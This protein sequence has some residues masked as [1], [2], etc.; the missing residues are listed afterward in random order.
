MEDENTNPPAWATALL[1]RINHLESRLATA[2]IINDDPNV[3]LRSPGSEFTPDVQMLEQ[4]PYLEEDFL[5]RPLSDSDRR[6]YFFECPKNSIQQYDPPKLNKV[7]VSAAHKQFDSHLHQI[8]FTYQLQNNQWEPEVLHNQSRNF[9]HTMQELLSNLASHIT[10]IRTDN[11]FKGLPASLEPPSL[12]TSETSLLDNKEM[13]EHI[14]LQQS[15]QNATQAKKH[16]H[17]PRPHRFAQPTG[18]SHASTHPNSGNP[19]PIP[20]S[21]QPQQ[22]T[23][24]TNA[25]QSQEGFQRRSPPRRPL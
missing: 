17:R 7:N 14:K 4:H 9:A 3:Q 19:T 25:T 15:V 2:N 5:R 10:Q 16:S 11:M 8:Q 20:K 24:N 22:A 21:T 12:D 18:S 1:Q 13:V 23:S 6:K